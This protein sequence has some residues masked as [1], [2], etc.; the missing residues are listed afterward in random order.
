M[1]GVEDLTTLAGRLA[2][3]EQPHHVAKR[4]ASSTKK[5]AQP[6]VGWPHK[7]PTP[8]DVGAYRRDVEA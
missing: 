4:R 2:T 6:S 7:T 5:K 3:F 1:D 8:D